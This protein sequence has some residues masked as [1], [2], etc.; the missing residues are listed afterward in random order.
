M[1]A[2]TRLPSRQRLGSYP[3]QNRLLV[4]STE[5]FF[6]E[7]EVLLSTTHLDGRIK[8]ANDNF[9]QIAGY[10]KE[11][12]V[13]A[14]HNIVRHQHMPKAAFADLWQ[15]IQSGKSWMGPVKNRCKNGDFYWVNAYV[16]PI[17]DSEGQ[18]VE[19][20]SVRTKPKRHIVN[21]ADKAYEQINA[22][23]IPSGIAKH[24]DYSLYF[25]VLLFAISALS[26]YQAA[27]SP[28]VVSIGIFL[29][30][31]ALSTI[32][33]V[34]RKHYK[35]VVK[36]AKSVYD[37][38]MM[39][40]LYTGNNDELSAISLAL[41]MRDAELRAIVGRVNDDSYTT[42]AR[43]K[44]SAEKGS[45]VASVLNNQKSEIEQVATAISQMS[46]TIQEIASVV[47]QASDAANK[48]SELSLSG[49]EKVEQSVSAIDSLAKQ[50]DVVSHAVSNLVTVTQSI[51]GVLGEISG[52]ADQTNLLALNAAIEAARAGDKGKGFAV[53]A[54]EVRA[55][56]M[57]T[58]T[59]TEEI[60][61]LLTQLRGDSEHAM[62]AVNVGS[63][64]SKDCV[65]SVTD[66]GHSLSTI[67]EE[68]IE[69][70]S[71]NTQIATAVE[72]QSVVATQ[73]NANIET[74]SET[75]GDSELCGI[76]AQELGNQLLTRL[77][78]QQALV[79]QFQ[80]TSQK[81]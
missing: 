23:K 19:Y 12:L 5:Q 35:A 69:L 43:A 48:S 10:S 40:Y 70:A 11:E 16:T 26:L 3:Y 79:S 71:M 75:S 56:A 25:Q 42:T 33:S 60:N 29:L 38:P 8:Y 47:T 54:E 24:T 36:K 2:Q 17:K 73:I 77:H 1:F 13:G 44:E 4:M 68:V 27:F 65:N 63:E 67:N 76:E 62:E 45:Q 18:T 74:I 15:H 32:F 57:R 53:V 52:I 64:L 81:A 34:W 9:C 21:R 7:G 20:Q 55:L 37:N 59:S 80:R 6:D 51:E 31:A 22:G 72:E 66:T 28:S 50:L 78:E 61:T 58:Q 41:Q 39:T 46:A 49:Q 14:H 30:V